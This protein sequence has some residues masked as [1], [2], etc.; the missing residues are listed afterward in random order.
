MEMLKKELKFHKEA[1]RSPKGDRSPIS[2]GTLGK[3]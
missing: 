3:Q 2:I 1:W